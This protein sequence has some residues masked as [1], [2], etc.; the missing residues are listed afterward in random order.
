M[1]LLPNATNANLEDSYFAKFAQ[2]AS[3]WWKYPALSTIS[4]GNNSITSTNSIVLDG[5]VITASEEDI[6]VNGVPLVNTST[7]TSSIQTWSQYKAISDVN[8]NNFNILSTLSIELDNV[9]LTA[10]VDELLINGVPVVTSTA[11]SQLSSINDWAYYEALSTVY[12]NNNYIVDCIGIELNSNEVTTGAGNTI[13]VNG[14]N[15]V[16]S[17]SGYTATGNVNMGLNNI[18]NCGSLSALSVNST[19]NNNTIM[20]SGS[21]LISTITNN[22]IRSQ[23][24]N[25]STLNASTVTSMVNSN[26]VS[27]ISSATISTIT[28]DNMTS[29]SISVSTIAAGSANVSTIN[30]L[31]TFAQNVILTNSTI[32]NVLTTVGSNLLYNGQILHSGT[33]G[34]V[35][36]WSLY[37]GVSEIINNR[38][39]ASNALEMT[40]KSYF[41]GDVQMRQITGG[42]IDVEFDRSSSDGPYFKVNKGKFWAIGSSNLLGDSNTYNSQ[43]YIA[44]GCTIDGG[45]LHGCSIGCLPVTLG[46][47]TM[48]IDVLPAGMLLTSPTTIAEV[49]TSGT[50]NYTGAMNI[51]TGGATAI[52]AGSYITLEHGFGVGANGIFIQDTAR[53][54][55]ARLLLEFGGSIGPSISSISTAAKVDY[56]GQNLFIQNIGPNPTRWPLNKD[57]YINSVSSIGF[58]NGTKIVASPNSTLNVSSI[59]TTITGTTV[60]LNTSTVNIQGGLFVSKYIDA[61]DFGISSISQFPTRSAQGIYIDA[62][63]VQNGNLSTLFLTCGQIVGN[64]TL[65]YKAQ[66]STLQ[67]WNAGISAQVPLTIISDVIVKSTITQIGLG[68]LNNATINTSTING[69][70]ATITNYSGITLGAVTINNDTLNN[71][72]INTS[73]INGTTATITNYNGVTLAA[74]SIY[75][76]TLTNATINTVIANGRTVNMSTINALS[77]NSQTMGTSTVTV[78]SIVGNTIIPKDTTTVT[79]PN[80][81]VST[82]QGINSGIIGAASAS[83]YYN[84]TSKTLFYDNV[85]TS[86]LLFPGTTLALAPSYNEQIFILTGA[87]T[88]NFTTTGLGLGNASFYVTIKN[89]TATNLTIQANGVNIPGVTSQL[90]ASSITGNGAPCY[91]YWDGTVLTMY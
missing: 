16:A 68:I 79:V 42:D 53:N 40:G 18:A 50:K 90:W 9:Y 31:S 8:F 12:M 32:S 47:N 15:P 80:L 86:L 62:N 3:N 35:S 70:T 17:W 24:A 22:N 14:Q 45:N 48:R 56:F 10:T 51:A 7:L 23:L 75:N 37:N 21:S 34:D 41:N 67:G 91:L 5:Q 26:V 59:T 54:D 33:G 43:T 36:Q 57:V 55:A 78:S 20:V 6:L 52:A 46:V 39:Y 74:I 77:V 81:T 89:G 66:T 25:I 83:V 27:Q 76:D 73:T 38:G 28:N 87:G 49:A 69:T 13:K 44:G 84:P 64:N 61:L 85:P 19:S 60:N 63:I 29:K 72:T 65:F 11:L 4:M 1:S 2:S 71:A 82:V 30:S 88:I 58:I